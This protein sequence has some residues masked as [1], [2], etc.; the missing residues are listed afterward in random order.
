MAQ[1]ELVGDVAHILQAVEIE[2]PKKSIDGE[3]LVAIFSQIVEP[4]GRALPASSEIVL[5]DLSLLPNSI[6]ALHGDVT[7]RRVGDPA[8]NILLR[9]LVDGTLR[10]AE[11]YET[12][13]P[14]GRRIRST[15]VLI[16]D[17]QGTP[18]AALCIN[19]DLSMWVSLQHLTETMVGGGEAIS[20]SAP[21]PVLEPGPGREA[22][23]RS[24]E[25]LSHH[26]VEEA[27]ESVGVPIELMKK[28]HKIHVVKS[29]KAQGMFL[30][31]DGIDIAAHT[32]RVSRFTIYN[33]LNEIEEGDIEPLD[34]TATDRNA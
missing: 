13:L 33:Y 31:R 1:N 22:F 25:E 28:R 8:T 2:R 5:H 12:V 23:S 7:G 19:T 29:L 34:P 9:K 27:I 4:L 16:H 17:V 20:R 26:I 18:V 6:V 11:A 10:G 24:V 32:L 21:L 15:T 3:R 30:L 14:D